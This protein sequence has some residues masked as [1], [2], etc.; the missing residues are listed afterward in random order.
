[1]FEEHGTRANEEMTI[2]FKGLPERR[3]VKCAASGSP[4]HAESPAYQFRVDLPK[5]DRNEGR[6]LLVAECMQ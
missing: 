4:T 2:P 3:F 1:M 6:H 5:Y